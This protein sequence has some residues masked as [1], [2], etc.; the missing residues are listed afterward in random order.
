MVLSGDNVPIGNVVRLEAGIQHASIAAYTHFASEFSSL[1]LVSIIH[2]TVT[3]NPCHGPCAR[4]ARI[5]KDN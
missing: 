1:P 2:H 4:Q 5:D 3:A